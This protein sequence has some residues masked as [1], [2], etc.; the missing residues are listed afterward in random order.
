MKKS[1]KKSKNLNQKEKHRAHV[2]E[3]RH[4]PLE[5]TPNAPRTSVNR[6]SP[7]PN[8]IQFQPKNHKGLLIETQICYIN[9]KFHQ[10][11]NKLVDSNINP[12]FY[13]KP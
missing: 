6:S 9:Q 13:S 2:V 11:N 7:R 5:D 8:P 12:N 1:T 10:T 4:V 3:M